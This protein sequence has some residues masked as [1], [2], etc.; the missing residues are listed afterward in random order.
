MT[1]GLGALVG[2]PPLAGFWSKDEILHVAGRRRRRLARPWLVS[3]PALLDGRRHRLVRDPAVAAHVLRRAA[4]RRRPRTPHEPPPRDGLAG[5]CVLAVP[6]ALLGFAG[7]RRRASRERAR[8]AR[9]SRSRLEPP[10]S[11]SLP[12]ALL[13]ARRR[14][15]RWWLWRRDPA[16]DPAARSGRCGRCSRTPST[17]T[18]VQDALV[19]RPV[20]ALARAVRRGRRVRWWTA[21]S[22]APAAATVGL[23]ARLAVGAPGRPAPRRRPP[24]SP[25]R[26]CSASP[27]SRS[28]GCGRDDRSAIALSPTLAAAGASARWS[29]AAAGRGRP[30]RPDRRPPSFAGG[31]VRAPALLLA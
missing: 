5:A 24:S 23:G 7:A 31:R 10:T 30:G 3:A 29:P 17:S 20:A 13:A 6:S 27:P 18:H 19:V 16:A 26:C 28:W 1:I 9:A 21:R 22:R 4:L 2:L 25:A 8:R 15:W 12:L 14:R 11:A